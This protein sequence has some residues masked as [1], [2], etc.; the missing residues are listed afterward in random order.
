MASGNHRAPGHKPNPDLLACVHH[1]KW[2]AGVLDDL[3]RRV[4]NF[5]SG[6]WVERIPAVRDEA[7]RLLEHIDRHHGRIDVADPRLGFRRVSLD[8][9][10][11]GWTAEAR[12]IVTR[13]RPPATKPRR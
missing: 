7:G 8:Q 13:W 6:A 2:R 4:E 11:A 3:R 12:T 10:P 1:F 5:T 9:L